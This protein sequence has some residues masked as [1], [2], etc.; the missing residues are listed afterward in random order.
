MN[1]KIKNKKFNVWKIEN[2]FYLKS[3]LSRILKIVCHYEIFK[4]TKNVKGDIL[5][6]GVFKGNSLIRLISF[7]NLF[8]LK[9][10]KVYGFDVFGSFPKQKIKEDNA[11]AKKHDLLIGKGYPI[12]FLK[13]SLDN[14]G[15]KNFELIKGDVLKTLP[16]F[17]KN[18]K[19]L[20]ISFLHLDLDVYE[21]TKFVLNH[22]FKMVSKN[23]VI[24]IDDYGQV[25]G[26]T[27]ATNEFLKKNKRLKIKSL[28]FHS[29][30]KF[31]VK[32]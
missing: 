6:F 8:K 24:L 17:L 4:I 29:R 21:P 2:L 31:I 27:K 12:T 11:F 15:L 25:A 10:K 22:L 28:K 5:E 16:K 9:R 32:S 18:K 20:K 30:L 3:N 19:K 26:A 1:K 23:G 13:K 7:R 14:K